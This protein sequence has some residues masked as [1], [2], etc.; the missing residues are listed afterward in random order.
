MRRRAS[1]AA[2]TTRRP[3]RIPVH[4]RELRLEILCSHQ[5]GRDVAH[6]ER[7]G[8][9][10]RS[11]PGS[12]GPRAVVG[13]GRVT[14]APTQRVSDMAGAPEARVEAEC[15]RNGPSHRPP[16]RRWDCQ[17]ASSTAPP[18]VP[19]WPRLLGRGR[20]PAAAPRCRPRGWPRRGGPRRGG[21]ATATGRSGAPERRPSR[22]ERA[23]PGLV[24]AGPGTGQ[25]SRKSPDFRAAPGLPRLMMGRDRAAR[26]DRHSSARACAVPFVPRDRSPVTA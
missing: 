17:V 19:R 16:S 23:A 7:P 6:A 13:P 2:R 4:A 10:E 8:N 14:S 26:A 25:P 12:L 24:L 22:K 3:S 18:G 20:P 9:G 21:S 5:V 1:S 11:A 15:R